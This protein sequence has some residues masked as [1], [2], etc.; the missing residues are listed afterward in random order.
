M[1]EDAKLEKSKKISRANVLRFK[2]PEQVRRA[3]A[4][5]HEVTRK[6]AADGLCPLARPEVRAKAMLARGKNHLG[7]SYLEK[8]VGWLLRQM[9][10]SPVDQFKIPNLRTEGRGE[11]SFYVDWALPD[12]KIAI[13]CD[14]A[15]WHGEDRAQHDAERQKAIESQG[16]LVLRFGEKAI[17]NNLAAVAD[18][19]RAVMANHNGEYEFCEA[20][21]VAIA[22][23]PLGR[24]RMRFNLGVDED[25]SF[26]VSGVVVHNCRSLLVPIMDG[27]T[28]TPTPQSQVQ[29]ALKLIQVGFGK[30]GACACGRCEP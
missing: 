2:D 13:E 15:A 17:R 30:R 24:A 21:I 11:R 7:G 5:A 22:T 29:A 28:W 26:I 8:K 16:W 12:L 19:I 6:M 25:Q 9:G 18:E 10:L 1:T 23:A 27:D 4:K 20:E 14:G 3:T